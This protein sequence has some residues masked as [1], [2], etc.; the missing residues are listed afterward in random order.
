[1]GV[2]GI[3]QSNSALASTLA[4]YQA[5]TGDWRNVCNEL[6]MIETLT[7]SSVRAAV[8]PYLHPLNSVVG[9]VQPL[10]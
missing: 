7:P 9:Y 3:L 1:M 2:L 5:L 4:S 8:T 10:L 6:E